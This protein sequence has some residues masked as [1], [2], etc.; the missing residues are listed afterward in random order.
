MNE[1][2]DYYDEAGKLLKKQA[3][4][5]K[6]VS[7]VWVWEKVVMT[8]VVKSSQTVLTFSDIRIGSGLSDNIFSERS[9]KAGLASIR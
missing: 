3:I 4:S 5:W 2:L 8:N 9:M 1:R 6:K 7:G